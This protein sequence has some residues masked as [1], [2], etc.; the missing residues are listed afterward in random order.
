MGAAKGE[1]ERLDPKPAVL[2]LEGRFKPC[3][4]KRGRGRRRMVVEM[5]LMSGCF[6]DV[7]LAVAFMAV[8]ALLLVCPDV[9]F[10][11]LLVI[12]SN[13]PFVLSSIRRSIFQSINLCRA[14]T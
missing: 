2:E 12:Q 14:D 9:L 13:C 6:D 5:M 11:V 3:F 10:P 7:G 4:G 1:L 8:L